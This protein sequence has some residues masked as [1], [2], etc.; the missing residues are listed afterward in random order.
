MKKWHCPNH[1]QQ[2]T[3]VRKDPRGREGGGQGELTVLELTEVSLGYSLARLFF[4]PSTL[5]EMG[6]NMKILNIF[7]TMRNS[8]ARRRL[9][10]CKT[11]IPPHHLR[12]WVGSALRKALMRRYKCISAP[13]AFFGAS[14]KHFCFPGPHLPS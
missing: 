9:A 1:Q 10:G 3:C 4:R 8:R 2:A 14:Q 5:F 12:G 11:L 7:T 13:N 6:I